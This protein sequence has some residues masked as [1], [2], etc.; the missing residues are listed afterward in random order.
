VTAR[1]KSLIVRSIHGTRSRLTR[2]QTDDVGVFGSPVSNEWRLIEEHFNL[3]EAQLF[4]LARK[5]I[6]VIFG[7]DEQKKR[8]RDIMW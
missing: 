7:G 2:Q 8:L 1:G 4:G 6:N 5:G 3:T